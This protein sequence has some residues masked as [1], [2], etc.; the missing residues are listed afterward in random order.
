[1]SFNLIYKY[2]IISSVIPLIRLSSRDAIRQSDN[3]RKSSNISNNLNTIKH[4]VVSI[5]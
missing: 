4:L 3:Q 1:M 2:D 5:R